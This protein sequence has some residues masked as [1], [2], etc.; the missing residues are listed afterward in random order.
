MSRDL[1][2]IMTASDFITGLSPEQTEAFVAIRDEIHAQT[3]AQNAELAAK[4]AT[5]RVAYDEMIAAAKAEAAAAVAKRDEL[6]AL[7]T[8]LISQAAQH[9]ADGNIDGVKAVLLA[10]QQPDKDRK[11]AEAQAAVVL[12]QANLD[13]AN[14]L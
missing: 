4:F 5:D 7:Q 8:S 3:G 6:I 13:A 2:T 9:F 12:A 10:A 1:R 14:A 11:I